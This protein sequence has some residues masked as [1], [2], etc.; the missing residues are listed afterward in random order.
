MSL[1]NGAVPHNDDPNNVPITDG[2]NPI[3]VCSD[4]CEN[5]CLIKEIKSLRDKLKSKESE[6]AQLK[7]HYTRK[8]TALTRKNAELKKKVIYNRTKVYRLS[9]TKSKLNATLK[10]LKKKKLL[11]NE[12]YSRNLQV[13][14]VPSNLFNYAISISNNFIVLII[15]STQIGEN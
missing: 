14:K 13:L 5:I 7:Y 2:I 4:E 6:N 12:E 9:N 1:R 11:T 8:T 15:S 3:R 10:Q